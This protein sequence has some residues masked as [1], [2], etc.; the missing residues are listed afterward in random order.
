[1]EPFKVIEHTA[2]IGLEISGRTLPELFLNST[3]GLLHLVAP[4]KILSKESG[5]FPNLRHLDIIELNAATDE[6]LLVY[7]LNEFIYYIFVKN[8]YPNKIEIDSLKDSKIRARVDFD[9]INKSGIS[10]EIKAATY[11][12]LYIKKVESFYQA[13]VIFDV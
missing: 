3:K 13:R 7:W 9:K 1:M 10:I 11:H 2:D 12:Q 5:P 8:K 6:E 4:K